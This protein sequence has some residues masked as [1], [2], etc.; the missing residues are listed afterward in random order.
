[1]KAKG[2][3]DGWLALIAVRGLFE[4]TLL[5]EILL[6]SHSW[7]APTVA[8]ANVTRAPV[9]EQKYLHRRCLKTKSHSCYD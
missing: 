5:N 9:A 3:M 4:L 6:D 1:M 2:E 7:P 8:G